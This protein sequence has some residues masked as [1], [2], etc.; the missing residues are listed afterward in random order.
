MLIPWQGLISYSEATRYTPSKRLEAEAWC[1]E[2]N[3]PMP[4]HT[5]YPRTKGFIASVQKLRHA[6]QIKAVYDVTIAYARKS[7]KGYDFLRPP[8]FAQS[9]LRPNLSQEWKFYVHVDR[10]I[11]KD[12][13]EKDEELAQWLESRWMEK[14]ERLEGL[15]R[16]L[17]AGFEWRP[18]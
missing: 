18:S 6:P 11:I 14:G 9:I 13:P 7:G 17:Q 2:H 3:K 16:T 15:R 1:R 8:S 10:H 4:L 5:L 12:L